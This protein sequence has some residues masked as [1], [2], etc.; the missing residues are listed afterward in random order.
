MI[1][2]IQLSENI[3]NVESVQ[4]EPVMLQVIVVW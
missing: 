2:Y 3:K 1:L 4:N